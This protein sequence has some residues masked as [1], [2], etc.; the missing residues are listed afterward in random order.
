MKRARTEY[1]AQGL[2]LTA[3]YEV[4]YYPWNILN[5]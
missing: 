4:S 3:G 1:Q 2:A 5:Q